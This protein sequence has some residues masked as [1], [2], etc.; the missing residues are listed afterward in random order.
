[1]YAIESLNYSVWDCKCPVVF[2]PKYRRR[3][4]YVE[5][6]QHLGDVCRPLA[7]QKESRI[8]EGHVLSDHVQMLLSISPK[9][10]VMQFVG[11]IRGKSAIH[12]ARVYL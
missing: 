1:M 8:E 11:F 3:A 4:L 12:R 7:R 9:H 5:L 10:A 2:I 6:R